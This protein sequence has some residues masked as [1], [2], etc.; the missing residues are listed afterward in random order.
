MKTKFLMRKTT[1]KNNL[2]GTFILILMTIILLSACG[3]QDSRS[4]PIYFIP[5]TVAV[6]PATPT[7][8]ATPTQEPEPT[9]PSTCVNNLRFVSDISYPD[10]TVVAPGQEIEKIWLVQNNGSCNWEADYTIRNVGGPPMGSSTIVAL[11]P[12]RSGG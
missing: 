12:V 11:Y 5:P 6:K 9:N 3:G 10:N 8:I 4:A 1:P 7:P 2:P